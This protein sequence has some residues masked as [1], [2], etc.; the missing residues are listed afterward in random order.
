[1]LVK[2]SSFFCELDFGLSLASSSDFSVLSFL[3]QVWYV[4]A[5]I[6]LLKKRPSRSSILLF[7][8]FSSAESL[9][10]LSFFVCNG[11]VSMAWIPD[12]RTAS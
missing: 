8:C 2:V 9:V 7:N 10:I 6:W 11:S 4:D 5:S 3:N 1:M 12:L